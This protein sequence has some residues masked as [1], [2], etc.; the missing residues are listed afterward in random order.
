MIYSL[1]KTCSH[2]LL[3]ILTGETLWRS[4]KFKGKPLYFPL[5]PGG[6]SEEQGH[7]Y[8]KWSNCAKKC[9]ITFESL[10]LDILGTWSLLSITIRKWKQMAQQGHHALS[11]KPESCNLEQ[12]DIISWFK[13]L[14]TLVYK[15]LYNV[16]WRE[17]DFSRKLLVM[18]PTAEHYMYL[19]S[20]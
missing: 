20:N 10:C 8:H 14:V 18:T 4:S 15:C 2:L 3:L 19:C 6:I 5:Y 17:M 13:C 11:K 12:N 1:E 9:W 7:L 16:I